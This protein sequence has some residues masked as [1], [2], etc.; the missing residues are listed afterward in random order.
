MKIAYLG[1]KG[2][3]SKS[4]AERA[5]EAVIT[6]LAGR[7]Q[8]TVYCDPAYTPGGTC[9]DGVRLVWISSLPGKHLKPTTYDLLG[10]LH[11]LVCGDYD[12]IHLHGVETA[13][14]APL[15][16]LRYPVIATAHGSTTRFPRAK[17]SRLARTLMGW[18]EYPFLYC[19]NCATSVSQIDA[20][21]YQERYRR[22]VRYIPNGVDL[23]VEAD[24]EAA[25]RLLAQY[26]LRPGQFLLFVAG[27]ID[28]TKG[29][30]LAIQAYRQVQTDLPLVVIGD[31][32][33]VAEYS[34]GLRQLAQGRRVIFIPPISERRLLF[35]LYQ[36]C[37]LFIFPSLHEGMSMVLLEAAGLG[38]PIVCSDIPENRIAVE[39]GVRYFHSGDI[40][41]LARQMAWALE[42]PQP[43]AALCGRLPASIAQRLSWERIAQT[44]HEL[45]ITYAGGDSSRQSGGP[46]RATP[47]PPK[48]DDPAGCV[49]LALDDPRWWA[50]V[51]HQP[52]AAIFHHPAWSGLLAQ[53]YG[54]TPFV[55]ARLD[56]QQQ[57]I[58]GLPLM[59]IDSRLTGRRWVGLP[60][61]DYCPPLY[62][63]PGDLAALCDW[64]VG[65]VAGRQTPRIEA[66]W[67]L[68]D[69][70]FQAAAPYVL[71]QLD[72]RGGL[73]AVSARLKRTHRQNI[74]TAQERGVRVERSRSLE[75][76][77]RFYA[78]Q[79]ETR[80]RQGVPVQPWKYFERLAASLF[81]QDLGCLWLAYR[82]EECLA[83]LVLL[84]WQGAATAK[85]AASRPDAWN[86]RSN[87]LLFW[88]AIQWSCEQGYT[89]FD[90]GRTEAANQGLRRYKDGWGAVETPLSY[91]SLARGTAPRLDGQPGL[92]A[93]AQ[94]IFRKS[95]A[96]V[97]RLA[98]ALLYPH[99]A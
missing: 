34:A 24:P 95:P 96:W 85:Y 57:V 12:L 69:S 18:M 6:R 61:S 30:H 82:G 44:Y 78:L 19:S 20:Q 28:P 43:M 38:A 81:A 79:V 62:Q 65:Q 5:A 88:S 77:R 35:A 33:Q 21:Y 45:Y 89:R 80:R 90:F 23:Q 27:R 40:Q 63:D 46:R 66:R 53:T 64:L 47:P 50:F 60:F 72:L 7:H 39:D 76:M 93:W 86:L 3:P 37:T 84:H 91:S 97:C 49:R 52:Q 9:L 14:V 31:L 94:A 8:L 4:G 56:D 55:V 1:L 15:L 68:P 13:F 54:Y 87:N 11:A 74:H 98:G 2:L 75:D 70:R 42:N 17:W 16:R 58:A 71:H 67:A 83:G 26:G 10:A 41:D 59:A 92:P 36:A 51:E 73:G 22:E 48:R 99:A 29:C 25:R 32:E